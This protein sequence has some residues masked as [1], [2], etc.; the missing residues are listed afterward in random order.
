VANA[1]AQPTVADKPSFPSATLLL[2]NGIPVR[3]IED[4][5]STRIQVQE[6]LQCLVG[7]PLSVV[8][9]AADM[10]VMHFGVVCTNPDKGTSIGEY[11]IHLQCPWRIESSKGI[12]VGD[13]DLWEPAN[14]AEE[15]DWD[16]W[17]YEKNEN[18]R[19]RLI[20]ELLKGTCAV[21]GS[22][23]NET[24]GLIVEAIE[25]DDFGGVRFSLTGGY[26]LALFPS[27]NEGENWRLL[28]FPRGPHFVISGGRVEV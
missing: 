9:K 14:A 22:P 7:L 24:G 28:P 18:L 17:H 23:R 19:D 21:T 6:H 2:L 27:G 25:A 10:C 13:S 16:T 8:H 1:E 4:M 15:I 20:G 11:A 12:L 26:V 5:E 3:Q